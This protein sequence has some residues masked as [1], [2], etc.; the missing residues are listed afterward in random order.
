MV[1]KVGL[2]NTINDPIDERCY[3]EGALISIFA[4]IHSGLDGGVTIYICIVSETIQSVLIKARVR[5]CLWS[6]RVKTTG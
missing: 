3:Q 6:A 2:T 5:F 1:L 4:R